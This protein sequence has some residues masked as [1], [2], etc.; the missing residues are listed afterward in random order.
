MAKFTVDRSYWLRGEGSAHSYLFRKDDGKMC[1]L[2]QILNRQFNIQYK[3]LTGLGEPA[4]LFNRSVYIEVEQNLIDFRNTVNTEL[5]DQAMKINDDRFRSEEQR[6]AELKHLFIA[7][8]H[9]LEVANG[10]S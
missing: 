4:E 10:R 5:V 1:C 6:E 2:G 9:E 3:H 7:Y 8:G